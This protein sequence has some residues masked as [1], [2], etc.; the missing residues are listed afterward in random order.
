VTKHSNAAWCLLLWL[1]LGGPSAAQEAEVAAIR[2]LQA[3]QEEAWN[4]HDAEAY[5]NLFTDDGDVVNVLGWWWR[6]RAEIRSRL[7]EAFA[8]VFRDSSLTIT[9]VH[10]RF[11][12][13][14][15]AVAHVRWT[16][17]GAMP[18]PG[19]PDPPR[20]GI[21]LQVLRKEAN[22]WLIASFQN[23][24]S[25]PETAF[26]KGALGQS[27]PTGSEG[28]LLRDIEKRR[29]R[30][31]VTGDL[32]T[33]RELHADDF[34]LINPFGG[35]LSKDQYL[36]MIQSGELKYLVWEPAEIAVRIYQDSASL[37]YRARI[38]NL[39]RG[40]KIS[41]REYWHTDV[42]EKRSGRW[43]VVYSHATEIRD[44]ID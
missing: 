43:Q 25:V 29:L 36:G 12:D 19:T 26:P 23:T 33:A 24:S 27:L 35:A 31:L 17:E 18:P 37:R 2:E 38:E 20:E 30:S 14:G 28:E 4:R 15:I 16:L 22:R 32:T 21:Q 8:F 41:L 13:P 9:E 11:L 44:G 6:G 10:V 5:A 39:V 1:G 7:T 3:R 34:Q 42:Y 40:Q